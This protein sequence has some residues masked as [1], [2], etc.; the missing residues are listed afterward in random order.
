MF[1][2]SSFVAVIIT[3]NVCLAV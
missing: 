3:L 2:Q 1:Y